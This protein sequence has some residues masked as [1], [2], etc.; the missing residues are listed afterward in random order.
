MLGASKTI[1]DKF[2]G[3]VHESLPREKDNSSEIQGLPGRMCGWTKRRGISGPRI[4]CKTEI[5]ENY[6]KLYD[7]GF[8]F[9][10]ED[11]LWKDSRLKVNGDGK[12]KSIESYISIKEKED[13]QHGD[14][15][16]L[17]NGRTSIQI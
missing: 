12:I 11:L 13:E 4:Y 9:H 3:S 5:V 17:T 10:M 16:T 7:S 6:L 8:D 15:D 1:T 14:S 2:I